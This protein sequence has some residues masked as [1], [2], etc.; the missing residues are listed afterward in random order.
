MKTY[1]GLLNRDSMPDNGIYVFGSNRVGINGNPTKGT[2]GAALVAQIEFGV[3]QGELMINR[4]SDSKK[5]FGIVTVHAP[6]VFL[7]DSDIIKNI[8]IFYS[9][10]DNNGELLFFVAYD[11][12]NPNAKLLNGRSRKKMASLFFNSGKIPKN[13][14]FEENFY[15]LILENKKGFEI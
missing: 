14:I 9:F 12:I 5:A 10:C 13:V 2:G 1:K 7:P 11:G 3:K 8:K 4:L 15:N 6:K